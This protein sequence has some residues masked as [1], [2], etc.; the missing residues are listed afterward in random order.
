MNAIRPIRH[1]SNSPKAASQQTCRLGLSLVEAIAVI[2]V[3]AIIGGT[4]AGLLVRASSAYASTRDTAATH[5]E[6]SAALERIA[7]ELRE[8]PPTPTDDH[9]AFRAPIHDATPTMIRFGTGRR[10]ALDASTLN[11]SEDD[12]VTEHPLLT[13]VRSLSI[14]CLDDQAQPLP[15]PLTPQAVVHTVSIA[16]EAGDP[17]RPV[18]LR[19]AVFLRANHARL[20]IAE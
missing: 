9:A 12:G 18:R 4:S 2:V 19:T 20:D 5:R 16:I 8:A 3:L 11:W 15:M 1:M 7:R 6:T 13:D 14:I 10:L 17:D